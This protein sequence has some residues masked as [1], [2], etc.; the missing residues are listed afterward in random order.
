MRERYSFPLPSVTI[1]RVE[2]TKAKKQDK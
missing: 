1:R 2:P